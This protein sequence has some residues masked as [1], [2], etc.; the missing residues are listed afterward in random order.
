MHFAALVILSVALA[1]AILAIPVP[2]GRLQGLRDLTTQRNAVAN[3][4]VPEV[5]SVDAAD[6]PDAM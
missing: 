5:R 1:P 3:S 6:A 2:L 4:S